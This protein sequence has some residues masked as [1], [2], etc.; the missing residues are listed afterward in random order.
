MKL[1]DPRADPTAAAATDEFERLQETFRSRLRGDQIRLTR[2]AA[3]LARIEGNPTGVFCALQTLA[4]RIRGAA[5][6]FEAAELSSDAYAL[7][8][9]ATQACG[10]GSDHADGAVWSTLEAL[11]ERLAMDCGIE[12]VRARTRRSVRHLCRPP[13]TSQ[14]GPRKVR[15]RPAK[16]R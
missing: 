4:H 12:V 1:T 3:S 11:V 5:A 7:E 8:Q 10:N 16:Q 13:E 6:I 14:S 9:A 2:L 15:S